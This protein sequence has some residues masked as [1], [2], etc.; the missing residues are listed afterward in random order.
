MVQCDSTG[1]N[2]EIVRVVSEAKGLIGQKYVQQ[3]ELVM[4]EA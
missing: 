1:W 2:C 4:K 3:T